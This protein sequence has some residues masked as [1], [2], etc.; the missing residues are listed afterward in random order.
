MST[1]TGTA[2]LARAF[3]RR[4]R[5][6][7]AVWVLAVGGLTAAAAS[8][9]KQLYPTQADLDEAARASADSAIA[10]AFKGP[11]LALDTVGGQVAFQIMVFGAIA[12]ALMSVL[13]M[14]RGDAG[15]GG[16]RAGSS[17]SG[18]CPSGVGRRSS[19]RSS[20]S[21]LMDV[22]AGALVDRRPAGPGPAG[23]RARW[24][25]APPSRASGSCSPASP[26]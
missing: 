2:V 1:L 15:R 10:R 11:P 19:P 12:V 24:S 16:G 25:S 17:W 22:A 7:I 26:R 4:D 14:T 13:M 23:G 18:P 6:R 20:S 8:S 3:A 5:T 21:P 9:V